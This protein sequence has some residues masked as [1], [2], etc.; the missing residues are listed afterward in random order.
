MGHYQTRHDKVRNHA[1]ENRP[2][3]LMTK[4]PLPPDIKSDR[5]R[6]TLVKDLDAPD[7]M[8]FHHRNEKHLKPWRPELPPQAKNLAYWVGWAEQGRMLFQ[9]DQACWLVVRLKDRPLEGVIGQVNFSHILRGSLQGCLLGYSI[10]AKHQG[11]GLMREA[12]ETGINF[13]FDAMKLHRVQANFI[14]ENVRSRKLLDRLGFVEEG[15]AKDY[16]YINGAWRD[17]V[18][19][20]KINP[21]VTKVTPD[22]Y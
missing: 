16:L 8:D 21:A 12:L 22:M 4:R 9:H 17:H 13:V 6:L 11:K 14:P 20:S 18:L 7:L 15:F 3:H 19:T 10:D 1:A 5:L 2:N